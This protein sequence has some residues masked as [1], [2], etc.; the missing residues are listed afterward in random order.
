MQQ[1]AKIK[2]SP[3]NPVL[4]ILAY[5]YFDRYSYASSSWLAVYNT[6]L[7]LWHFA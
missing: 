6:G 1:G 7:D 3:F 5:I 2:C 4:R